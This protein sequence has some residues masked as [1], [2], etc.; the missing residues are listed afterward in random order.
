MGFNPFQKQDKSMLD[1]ALVVG[2]VL[3]TL[4]VVAWAFFG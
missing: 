2:F 1:V 3:L 4:A